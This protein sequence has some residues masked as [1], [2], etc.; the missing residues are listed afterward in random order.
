LAL[1]ALLNLK[2]KE[3]YERRIK[4]KSL[5][6]VYRNSMLALTIQINENKNK[7]SSV[8]VGDKIKRPFE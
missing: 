6:D 1:A 5:K 4:K 2:I 7:E 3:M 8:K